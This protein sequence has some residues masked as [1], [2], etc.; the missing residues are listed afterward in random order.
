[1]QDA[2]SEPA[3]S[4]THSIFFGI[5]HRSGKR[6]STF[7]QNPTATAA[8]QRHDGTVKLQP[9]WLSASHRPRESDEPAAILQLLL[10]PGRPKL[11]G[12]ANLLMLGLPSAQAPIRPCLA[13]AVSPDHRPVA[14]TTQDSQSNDPDCKSNL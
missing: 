9:S 3:G 12:D 1:M 11:K 10:S 7:T 14:S 6:P 8:Q 2:M 5:R 13:D 4:T